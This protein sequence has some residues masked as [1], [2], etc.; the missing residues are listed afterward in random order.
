MLELSTVEKYQ[1]MA[2]RIDKILMNGEFSFD[3]SFLRS[4]HKYL[5]DE[6]LESAGEFRQRNIYRIEDV[7]HGESV[8]YSN[9]FNIERYL[10]Y[11]MQQENIHNYQGLEHGKLIR[12][13]CLL[14]TKLWLTHPFDDG[15]T[16][17]ISV[18]MRL[19]FK[20]LGYEFDNKLFRDDFAYYRDALVLASYST[21]RTSPCDEYLEIFFRKILF[22][23]EINLDNFELHYDKLDVKI[24]TRKE[25]VRV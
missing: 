24:K 20:K 19:L 18:F 2:K 4:I 10:N 3:V 16:R 5:F 7:L 11:D 17:T 12:K 22:E 25:I 6:L 15:N 9:F 8:T 21:P 1:I 14:N 23:P 13:F